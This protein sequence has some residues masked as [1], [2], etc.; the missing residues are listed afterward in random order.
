MN[1]QEF[2]SGFVAVVGRPNAGKSTLINSLIGSKVSIV[3]SVPQ[4]T[5]HQIKGILN[6]AQAQVVFV[7]TPGMHL[8]QEA[9]AD[10]L[11]IV[12]RRSLDG[13]DL[14]VY[15]IDAS[16]ICGQEEEKIMEL[17]AGQ[18]IKVIMVFNKMDIKTT[19]VENYLAQWKQVTSRINQDP[20]I[21]VM[22]VSAWTGRKLP[23]LTKVIIQHL[24]VQPA[25]YD[26][27]TKTDF[28]EKFRVAD[29]IREQL[30]RQLKD[31]LPHNA[32]VEV[33]DQEEQTTTSG[34]PCLH[35][36]VNIYVNRD[37][38]K[39]IVIGK[40][41]AMIKS[42]GQA[43]RLTLERMFNKKVFL[44]LEVEVLENWQSSPRILKELGYWWA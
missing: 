1:K 10:H 19:N 29:I 34:H 3:S 31:E 4:T 22:A 13:C 28:P 21:E 30:C 42:I 36:R 41:G 9:L 25:F 40:K 11:N 8:F 17:L 27:D 24:P 39:Q 5:R 43:S 38:Q 12:A 32:A 33:V 7:D 35:I 18:N 6:L 23:D 15:V 14:I 37:S 44:E 2:K 16:R 26:L 20:V